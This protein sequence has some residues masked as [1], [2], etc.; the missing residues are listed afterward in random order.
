MA[1]WQ[2]NE[3]VLNFL[4]VVQPR[5]RPTYNTEQHNKQ[6]AFL[7]LI[8]SETEQTEH[9]RLTDVRQSG[10]TPHPECLTPGSNLITTPE[11]Q[12]TADKNRLPAEK[13]STGHIARI[14]YLLRAF[15]NSV[16]ATSRRQQTGQRYGKQTRVTTKVDPTR[17]RAVVQMH[18]EYAGGA[19]SAFIIIL[20]VSS[21]LALLAG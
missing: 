19:S 15:I 7:S 11:Q 12:A 1:I 9:N 18:F 3:Y 5:I 6:S 20:P 21:K 13:F 16:D 10:N 2:G 14:G 8:S 4:F 17:R